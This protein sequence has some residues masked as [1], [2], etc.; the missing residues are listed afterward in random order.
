MESKR[1]A[2]AIAAAL[3]VASSAHA[4]PVVEVNFINPQNYSDASPYSIGTNEKDRDWALAELR[5]ELEGLG[6]RLLRSDD[7]LKLDVLDVDLAGEVQRSR[8]GLERRVLNE[9]RMPRFQI[10][11]S[12]NRAGA[13]MSGEERVTELGYLFNPNRCRSD[14]PLCREKTV[15]AD[16]FERTFAESGVRRAP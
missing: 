15:L 6:A 13:E 2:L 10:R 5:K 16:W 4:A 9:Q 8:T 1:I 7:R 14:E 11:Y 3:M 12:L